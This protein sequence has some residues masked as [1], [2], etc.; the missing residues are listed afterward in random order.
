PRRRAR[1]RAA[2]G[3]RRHDHERAGHA[4]LRAG[5]PRVIGS[6]PDG[7][8]TRTWSPHGEIAYAT[9]G[10]GTRLR[11]LKAG[12]GPTQLI[13]LHTV[14]TQLD[15]FQPVIPKLLQAFTV[16]AVDMPGMGWSDINPGRRYTE[17]ELR[18]ALA[19]F[20]TALDIS[21]VVMAGES[22]GATIALTA[23][24]ELEG[25]VGGGV[26]FNPY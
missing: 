17:P 3:R 5:G 22:M 7:E 23:S 13:L 20:V 2:L 21:G 6:V 26:A 10:D 11:Y 9:L 16:H 25:R 14:R 8:Y 1:E 15:P 19:E 18:Q 12:S 4:Y 24:T